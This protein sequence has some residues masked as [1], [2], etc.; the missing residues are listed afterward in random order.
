M[1]HE[2]KI[3]YM[4]IASGISTFGFKHE[5]LDLLV[6]LY[7][8]VMDKKGAANLKDILAIE[9][10]VAKRENARQLQQTLDRVSR[11]V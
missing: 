4:R 8:H 5:Q 11:K 7:E 9:V 10:V 6:S 1:T 2:E 3:N